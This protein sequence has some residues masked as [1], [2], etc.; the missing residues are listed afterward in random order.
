MWTWIKRIGGLLALAVV[1]VVGLALTKADTFAVERRISIKA[2]P[3][4]IYPLLADFQQFGKWSPWEHLDPAMTRS[5][6]G[7]ASGEGS[8]YVW[9]GNSEVGEGRMEIKRA[10]PPTKVLIKLDFI[11]PFA[12]QNMAEYTLSPKGAETE[13]VWRM[14]GPMPFVSKVMSVF[15]SMDAMIG[16]DFERGLAKLKTVVEAGAK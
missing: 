4:A 9:K 5:F 6:S 13:M 11:E 1:V 10:E 2:A 8:V 7:P 3:D 15:V 14:T 12:S 16:P